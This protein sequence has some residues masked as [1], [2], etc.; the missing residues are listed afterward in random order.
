MDLPCFWVIGF[1][2]SFQSWNNVGERAYELAQLT[3]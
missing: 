2:E 3:K 1:L